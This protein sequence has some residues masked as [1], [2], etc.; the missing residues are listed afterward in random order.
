MTSQCPLVLCYRKRKTNQIFLL[1]PSWY[2]T[3]C[4]YIYV[5]HFYI[6][7]RSGSTQNMFSNTYRS[8]LK[9]SHVLQFVITKC[10]QLKPNTSGCP[11]GHHN[12]HICFVTTGH[13]VQNFICYRQTDT[14]EHTNSVAMWQVWILESFP[15]QTASHYAP[16]ITDAVSV[17]LLASSVEPAERLLRLQKFT[18][19][20]V[21]STLCVN[22]DCAQSNA[23][24]ESNMTHK[25]AAT[26][27]YCCNWLLLY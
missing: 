24:W 15:S 10:L 27:M 14:Q 3:I 8:H 23:I 26:L 25:K 5:I 22:T 4:N 2:C 18:H 19:M 13:T 7:P 1:S 20:K 12:V 16:Y 21:T 11:Q 17:C 9:S 6:C